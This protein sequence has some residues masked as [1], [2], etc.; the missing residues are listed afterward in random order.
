MPV[1]TISSNY[2]KSAVAWLW[3]GSEGLYVYNVNIGRLKDIRNILGSFAQNYHKDINGEFIPC[4]IEILKSNINNVQEGKRFKFRLY[5]D[6]KFA[7][8]NN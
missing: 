3:D 4:T 6:K 7:I 2:E 1:L 5:K 8:R